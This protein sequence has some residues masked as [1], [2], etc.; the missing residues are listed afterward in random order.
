MNYD[1]IFNIFKSSYVG[2][3]I[4]KNII[5][6]KIINKD[7]KDIINR[8]VKDIYIKYSI[9]SEEIKKEAEKNFEEIQI[10]EININDYR[11][12]YDIYGILLSIIPYPILAIFRYN[13]R[14]SFA[15]SNRILAEEKNNKGKIFTSYL[16]KEEDISQYLKIDINNCQT[17]IDVYN[18][19]IFNIKD[20]VAY[21]ERLDRVIEIIEI[22]FHIKSD[23]VLEKLESYIV[24]DCGTYNMK[25]KEGWKSKLEKYSD[26]SLFVKKVETHI[27]WEYLSENT[28]LKNKLEDFLSWQD[29]KEACTYNNSL[30]DIY[31]SQYNSKMSGDY[32]TD[33]RYENRR[34][35]NKYKN[36]NYNINVDTINNESKEGNNI[37]NTIQEK[38]SEVKE[39][40]KEI[41][42]EYT[43]E[44]IDFQEERNPL[45]QYINKYIDANEE[46]IIIQLYNIQPHIMMYVSNVL[47]VLANDYNIKYKDYIALLPERKSLGN[48]WHYSMENN[49]KYIYILGLNIFNITENIIKQIEDYLLKFNV[50]YYIEKKIDNI[51][52]KIYPRKVDVINFIINVLESNNI[53]YEFNDFSDSLE[54]IELA[55]TSLWM[56]ETSKEDKEEI[57][58]ILSE[59]DQNV[60]NRLIEWGA[61]KFILDKELLPL[62]CDYGIISTK[63]FQSHIESILQSLKLNYKVKNKDY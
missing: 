26:S 25:P 37:V 38:V 21:Y 41:I 35:S 39:K 9:K 34:N 10:I 58:R 7:D 33:E 51:M 44:N 43:I 17:M 62:N 32:E 1:E 49:I 18:E 20:T 52:L 46:Y 48:S 57:S 29:F 8:F 27:L 4:K 12:I 28:F 59:T 36:L 24:R 61:P 40:K 13:D 54:N 19:W 23:A 14:I 31:Y 30:N 56:F 63:E 50:K 16:I 6:E 15:V 11:A 3:E 45:H 55:Q 60:V 47:N 42:E 5:I 2:R 53:E 22:G